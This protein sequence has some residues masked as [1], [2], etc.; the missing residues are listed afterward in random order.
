MVKCSTH[1]Q[2]ILSSIPSTHVKSQGGVHT[3]YP[4]SEEM[5]EDFRTP[6]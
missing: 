6:Q 5:E 4:S 2:E 1:R 3:C